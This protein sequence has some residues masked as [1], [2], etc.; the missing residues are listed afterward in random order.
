MMA[1]EEREVYGRQIANMI[2]HD[3][4]HSIYEALSFSESPSA[5]I[6]LSSDR[7]G[8]VK[9]LVTNNIV[10]RRLL[11]GMFAGPWLERQQQHNQFVIKWAPQL[12]TLSDLKFWRATIAYQ[13]AAILYAAV[14][15]IIRE[16]RLIPNNTQSDIEK[17]L[18]GLTQVQI[19][20]SFFSMLSPS[21][22]DPEIITA[23]LEYLYE[24]VE[25]LRTQESAKTP[26][27]LTADRASDL[28]TFEG[29]QAAILWPLREMLRNA[30]G[31][32][33]DCVKQSQ[34]IGGSPMIDLVAHIIP[35]H[36]QFKFKVSNNKNPGFDTSAVMPRALAYFHSLMP[37]AS[38]ED[39]SNDQ[40]VIIESSL[41]CGESD[42][43]G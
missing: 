7:S 40:Q 24:V 6:S 33:L 37:G 38:I 23:D 9:Q 4:A 29:Q 30:V 12:A 25:K 15:A 5:L 2:A 14:Y 8:P 19:R 34:I 39:L 20:Y 17:C 21:Q 28:M 26:W 13:A 3:V 32:V 41:V 31:Y 11:V 27:P 16:V 43:G 1:L 22:S 42:K 36:R 18:T 10:Q 35:E